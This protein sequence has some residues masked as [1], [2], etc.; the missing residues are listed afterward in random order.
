MYLKP[1]I[2]VVVPIYNVERYVDQC[3]KSILNQSFD[4]FEL[5]LVDD[6][7]PDNC[8]LICDRYAT[9][10]DRIK[11]IHKEN[12]G[13]SDAR[14]AG[15]EASDGDYITFIDGDDYVCKWYLETLY[16]YQVEYKADIVQAK[17]TYYPSELI[18]KVEHHD[19][20]F[21]N[22]G[23][24]AF[25]SLLM[26]G[27]ASEAS[28]V[29][30]YRKTLFDTI[31]FPIG[32]INEDTL[33]TYKLL[34]CSK[35]CVFIADPIYFYRYNNSGILH[36][37]FS[38]IRFSILTVFDE[39]EQFLGEDKASFMNELMY[40]K[41][42]RTLFFYNQCVALTGRKRY[43]NRL[44]IIRNEL[45]QYRNYYHLLERKYQLLLQL[46]H[47]SPSVYDWL[48]INVRKRERE[49]KDALE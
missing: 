34:K 28:C 12:G 6:G 7:S 26:R 41:I 23:D 25:K 24:E 37:P 13:L 16:L 29:K 8:G 2:S 18:K 36:S 22:N 38:E 49:Y 32:R 45:Y 17:Y 21:I 10:D 47:V 3:I 19:P 39:M 30:L 14:N 20:L 35:T 9:I 48:V 42:R 46:L 5:I 27:E 44:E 11:V 1:I 4:K 43:K 40:Y 15:I 33:T 31:R